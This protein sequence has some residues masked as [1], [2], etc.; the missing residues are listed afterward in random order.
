LI[1]LILTLLYTGQQEG[2][3]RC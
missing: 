3:P 2:H 1:D